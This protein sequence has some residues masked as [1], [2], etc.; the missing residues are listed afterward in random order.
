MEKRAR[1]KRSKALKS[2]RSR[3]KR[4]VKIGGTKHIASIAHVARHSK[5][6]HDAKGR[7]SISV[8]RPMRSDRT[9]DM[10]YIL[11]LGK[12]CDLND[13]QINKLMNLTT[14]SGHLDFDKLKKKIEEFFEDKNEEVP[15]VVNDIF[16]KHTEFKDM[17]SLGVDVDAFMQKARNLQPKKP[18]VMNRARSL[19]TSL[20]N[21]LGRSLQSIS[22]RR[23][24]VKN[25]P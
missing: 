25:N 2:G 14:P 16:N 23:S 15:A 22:A 18:S 20:R 6:S 24:V 13:D 8:A 9:Y 4:T 10:A 11:Y 7:A 17:K 21:S 5:K 3:K 19:G 12:I 1:T